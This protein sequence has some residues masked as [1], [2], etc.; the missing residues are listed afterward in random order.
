MDQSSSSGNRSSSDAKI[1]A[2]LF[3]RERQQVDQYEKNVKKRKAADISREA[4]LTSKLRVD[5]NEPA[6]S[7]NESECS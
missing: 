6:Q 7:L 1:A 5:F 2:A 4:R 3:D